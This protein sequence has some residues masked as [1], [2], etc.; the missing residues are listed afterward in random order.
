MAA[1][2]VP[3]VKIDRSNWS[4]PGYNANSSDATIGYSSQEAIGEGDK[5][6]LKNGR[7]TS[8]IDSSLN[9]YWHR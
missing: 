6:G 1:T 5:D 9:T 3:A 8:M 4:F 2:P 7:V